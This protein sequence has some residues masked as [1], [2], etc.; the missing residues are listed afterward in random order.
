M[1]FPNGAVSMSGGANLGG[2]AGQCLEV[3]GT[4][5][6]LSGGSTMAT[7]CPSLATA[8]SSKVTLVQ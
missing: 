6:S 4:Q 8:S 2:G 7:S 1:Y 3:V 5:V